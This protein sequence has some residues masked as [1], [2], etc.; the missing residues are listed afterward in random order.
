MNFRKVISKRLRG[1][2][3]N[4]VI[5]ANVGERGTVSTSSSRQQVVRRSR[6]T[7]RAEGGDRIS[8]ESE[9]AEPP[10]PD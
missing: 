4:V 9:Q 10:I 3:A 1:G 6:S 5:S 2:D 8:D 7:A